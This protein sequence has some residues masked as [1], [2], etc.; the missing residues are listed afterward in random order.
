MGNLKFWEK[1]SDAGSGHANRH[2][3]GDS[4]KMLGIY[5]VE[6]ELGRGSMG[7][8]YLGRDPITGRYVAIKTLTLASGFNAQAM[9]DAKKHFLREA[10]IL[11]WLDHPDI[12][13]IYDVGEENGLAYIA[14]E[15]LNGVEL[16]E[17]TKPNN[18][19][20]LPKTLEIVARV[21]DALGYVHEHNVKHGDVKPGNIMFDQASN[22]V[23]V[24]DFGISRLS[25]LSATRVDLL[26]GTPLYMSPEQVMR[27]QING[28]SD[29]F[30][31]GSSLYQLVS[32]HL[33]FEGDSDV[34]VMNRIAKEPHTDILSF[35][36]DLPPSL[37][38]VINK[39]LEKDMA[40]RFQSGA[41]LAEAI[42]QCAAMP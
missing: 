40:T 31:L 27:K 8:V 10:K 18:L 33:P 26:L 12:V 38:A 11:T 32:G 34:D 37:C 15:F 7:V 4:R 9:G 28:L 1:K 22:T 16:T 19:L 25:N 6:R 3:P 5:D 23:K 2:M 36:P 35:K 13:T 41:E 24:M 29:L 42:R 30:S 21:A 14:M 39:A 20:P 17:H